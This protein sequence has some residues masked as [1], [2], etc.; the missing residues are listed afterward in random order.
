MVVQRMIIVSLV[1]LGVCVVPLSA[2]PD[3]AL[4]VG[5][6]TYPDL[7]DEYQLQGALNDVLVME[8][9]LI[10]V[11]GFEP[12]HIKTLRNEEASREG[13]LKTFREFLIMDATRDSQVVFYFSGHGGQVYDE[14][15]D[16]PGRYDESL[17]PYD[18]H[19]ERNKPYRDIID[20][21]I[22]VLLND[23]TKKCRN[24]TLIFDCCHAG[25]GYK[26]LEDDTVKSRGVL[27]PYIPAHITKVEEGEEDTFTPH[28]FIPPGSGTVLLAACRQDE[29]AYEENGQ[30]VF[31]Q[32]LNRVMRE[33][34]RLTYRQIVYKVNERMHRSYPGQHAQCSGER[35]DVPLFGEQGITKPF[36]EV[37]AMQGDML[38]INGGAAHNVTVGSMYKVYSPDTVRAQDAGKYLCSLEITGVQ[39]FTAIGKISDQKKV[40]ETIPVRALAFETAHNFGD[41]RLTLRL[42]GDVG[43]ISGM[44]DRM[45]QKDF[46]LRNL[47]E[48][49][50]EGEY[51]LLLTESPFGNDFLLLRRE[52]LETE[53]I[54]LPAL[55]TKSR[56]ENK[57]L[58]HL[59]KERDRKEIMAL[60]HDLGVGYVLNFTRK[61]KLS[62]RVMMLLAAINEKKSLMTLSNAEITTKLP[63][64]LIN[65]ARYYN[66]INL[67]NPGSDLD[68]S[69]RVRMWERLDPIAGP[70]NEFD[71]RE[72][73]S[74][75]TVNPGNVV[76][77]E[78]RNNMPNTGIYYAFLDLWTNRKISSLDYSDGTNDV[79]L[80]GESINF[81]VKKPVKFKHNIGGFNGFKLIATTVYTDFSF[82]EQEAMKSAGDNSPLGLLFETSYGVTK[83]NESVEPGDWCTD[84]VSVYINRVEQEE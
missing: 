20:D 66:V 8:K 15:N 70:V 11:F 36:L 9:L 68:V 13:I 24:V 71:L 55:A 83:S 21:E 14:N 84:M 48:V 1:M 59:S 44:I 77:F 31:T 41:L 30:G 32:A 4:L 22:Q 16:E 63:E 64:L 7:P 51:D 38:T 72:F 69:L 74:M 78:I 57:I 23:L 45:V 39:S 67:S 54:G 62:G 35:R 26:A 52:Q 19:R 53:A 12:A 42:D 6:N 56:L 2:G 47:V 25:S 82:L 73:D 28:D 79:L 60:Y 50:R 81:P 65:E 49:T 61:K 10:E 46:R 5:I 3:L 29:K 33:F 58:K 34:P 37:L 43:K 27:H 18:A 40:G 80:P 17:M 76:Q 75:I